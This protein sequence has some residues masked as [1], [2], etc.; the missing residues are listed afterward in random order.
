MDQ[1]SGTHI[2][3]IVRDVVD[4]WGKYIVCFSRDSVDVKAFLEKRNFSLS[5]SRSDALVFTGNDESVKK[6]LSEAFPGTLFVWYVKEKFFLDAM[7]KQEV[8]EA[9]LEAIRQDATF[10]RN[11]FLS[12]QVTEFLLEIAQLKH[13][14]VQLV[15]TIVRLKK[16]NGD[17]KWCF[18]RC[19]ELEARLE[20][21]EAD[22]KHAQSGLEYFMGESAKV[23]KEFEE[24]KRAHP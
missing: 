16:E 9:E 24:Y 15:A 13:D 10:Q 11:V 18:E 7:N 14:Q 20:K 23:G 2:C 22:R 6:E 3:E 5:A 21:S 19:K 4:D 8:F 1:Q 17:L 12:N